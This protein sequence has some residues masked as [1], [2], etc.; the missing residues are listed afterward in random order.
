MRQSRES[1]FG[2]FLRKA[3]H[4]IEGSAQLREGGAQ[5][6]VINNDGSAMLALTIRN[7]VTINGGSC[8]AQGRFDAAILM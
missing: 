5:T 7:L 2:T 6:W 8:S 4:R 1:R 3:S